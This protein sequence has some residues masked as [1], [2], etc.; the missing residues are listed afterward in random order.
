MITTDIKTLYTQSRWSL[1]LRGLLGLAVGFLILTRP[2]ASVA[3]FALVIAVW[4]FAD[5]L[6]N[7]VRAFSLR[8]VVSHWWLFLVAGV[9]G[10]AFGVA[11]MYY[12]PTLSLAFAVAWTALWLIFAGLTGLWIGAQ[13]RKLGMSSGW[14]TTFSLIALAAG[15]L[16]YV[17]PKATLAS[18]MLVIAMFGIIEG[19]VMLMAAAKLGSIEREVKRGVDQVSSNVEDLRDRQ[20]RDDDRGSRAA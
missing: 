13:E 9:I 12:Y 10:V 7:I 3:A 1:I 16:A 15:I 14:T 8:N 4:A 20:S 11:A 18:L 19:V 17:Y 6:A 2:L 5:G